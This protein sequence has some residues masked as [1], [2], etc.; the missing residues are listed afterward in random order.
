MKISMLLPFL[1]NWIITNTEYKVID[2]NIPITELSK[3]ELEKKACNGSCPV[4]AFFQ[5]NKGIFYRKMDLKNYCNQ[6][7]I[8]HEVIHAIQTKKKAKMQNVFREKEAYEIQNKFL[9][10][11]S[12]KKDL[13]E[14]LNVRKCRSKQ[15]F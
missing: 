1:V 12:K 11:I 5:P 8:L 4:V 7:I 15:N 6:S 14:Y 3:K 2:F 10:Y 13:L 9:M